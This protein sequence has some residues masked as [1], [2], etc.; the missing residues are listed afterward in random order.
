VVNVNASL[1]G[2]WNN[3]DLLSPGGL[4][5]SH[6]CAFLTGILA[7]YRSNEGQVYYRKVLGVNCN[8]FRENTAD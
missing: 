4:N 5:F 1:I 8:S 7:K 3:S 6:K 2:L